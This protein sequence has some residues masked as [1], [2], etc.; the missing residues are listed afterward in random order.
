MKKFKAL[1]ASGRTVSIY[2]LLKTLCDEEKSV[3][4][5]STEYICFSWRKRNWFILPQ[6]IPVLGL[7]IL[8]V[9]V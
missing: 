6:I 1:W 7:Y 4:L 2:A 8:I 5:L 9:Y 3:N